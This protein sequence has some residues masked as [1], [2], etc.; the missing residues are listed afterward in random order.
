MYLRLKLFKIHLISWIQTRKYEIIVFYIFTRIYSR[1]FLLINSS[2][3]LDIFFHTIKNT[4]NLRNSFTNY[5]VWSPFCRRT[6]FQ[7]WCYEF[8]WRSMCTCQSCKSSDS[9]QRSWYRTIRSCVSV[10][11][12]IVSFTPAQVNTAIIPHTH[13]HTL[14]SHDIYTLSEYQTSRISK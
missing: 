13:T 6:I 4:S 1:R 5:Y 11:Y 7:Q 12:I 8:P 9:K 10:H 2:S 14:S 3:N